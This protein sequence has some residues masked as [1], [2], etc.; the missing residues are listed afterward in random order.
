[1]EQ[2][3]GYDAKQR[4]KKLRELHRTFPGRSHPYYQGPCD[5]CGDLSSPVAPHSENYSEPF[6]WYRP[7]VFALCSTCHGRV[8]K[9]FNAPHAW[10]AYKSHLRRGGVGSD[11]KHPPIAR[12][13]ARFAKLI[14]NGETCLLPRLTD[15]R[16]DHDAW[17]EKLQP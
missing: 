11:L 14:A 6:E 10:A 13:I 12:E 7:A 3:N 16:H 15:R 17:W 4:E 9:R 8:H 1:M 5:M 2:Y